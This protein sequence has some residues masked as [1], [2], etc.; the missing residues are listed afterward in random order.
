MKLQILH[1]T[2]YV[3][4]GPVCRSLNELRLKPVSADGQSCDFFTV[5]IEPDARLS[6]YLDFYFNYVQVFEISGTHRELSVESV[7]RVTTSA[8]LLPCGA[9][10]AP[11][12]S[13]PECAQLDWCYDFLQPS[14]LVSL[15]PEV[16][17]L[18]VDACQ[19]QSDVWQ[20]A[21]AIM[22]FI[23]ANFRYAPLSTSVKTHMLEVIEKRHGVCQDFTHVMLGMCRALKIPAR[24][25]SGYIY[26]GPTGQLTGAQASH[27][28]CEVY[29]PGLGWRGLDP[30]NKQLADDRYV[31]VAVGRDYADVAP[32]KGQ[33]QGLPG[34]MMSVEVQV[35]SFEAA[36]SN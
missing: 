7:A 27:A 16:W 21:L 19:G 33:Y 26:N 29:L 36:S 35:S 30:T 15:A 17:R 25:I 31:K 8:S 20:S 22:H 13:L 12:S 14:A 32:I 34:N 3:Y 18:A 23:H 9:T 5:K 6:H 10:I 4:A 2:V 11:L 1:R 28:W 24:Y